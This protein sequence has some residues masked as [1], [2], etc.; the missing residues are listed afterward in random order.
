MLTSFAAPQFRGT[1]QSQLEK[2]GARGG[3][4]DSPAARRQHDN[5]APRVPARDCASHAA[6]QTFELNIG[7][8]L[9]IPTGNKRERPAYTPQP[10]AQEQQSAAAAAAND[11]F[12]VW[13]SRG[14]GLGGGA[15]AGGRAR[16]AL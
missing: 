9:F 4:P 14:W 1:L 13:A 7:G 16:R 5:R 10:S 15:L 12:E 2:V 3:A 8:K 11:P 6:T